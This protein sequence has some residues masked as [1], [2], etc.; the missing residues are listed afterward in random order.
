MKIKDIIKILKEHQPTT[1]AEAKKAG[2][3]LRWVDEGA[4]RKVY[5]VTG[6]PY[7]IK[8]PVKAADAREHAHAEA[9]KVKALAHFPA[10]KTL[11]PKIYFHDEKTGVIVMKWYRPSKEP[12]SEQL[13]SALGTISELI[14]A[15]TKY[16]HTLGDMYTGNAMFTSEGL[17]LLDL[18]FD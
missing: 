13:D 5:R 2:I 9:E 11:L 7:V 10:V 15:L 8:F 6:A 18:G 14:S 12:L 1:A 17:T 4:Y 3:P 16:E